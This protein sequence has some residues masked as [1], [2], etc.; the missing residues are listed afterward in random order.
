MS[1]HVLL[2]RA[3]KEDDDAP[4]SA[5]TKDPYE[6]VLTPALGSNTNVTSV[7][8][9]ETAHTLAEL[10]WILETGP[11][12]H[13]YKGVVVT[14]RRAVEAWVAAAKSVP[15]PENIGNGNGNAAESSEER[16]SDPGALNLNALMANAFEFPSADD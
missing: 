8:V 14:S 7:P 11:A 2:L 16:K 6:A 15:M 5:V 3:P 1:T 4:A 12:F 10:S 13:G 9:Y